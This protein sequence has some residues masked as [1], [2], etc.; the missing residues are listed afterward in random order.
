MPFNFYIIRFS[1]AGFDGSELFSRQIRNVNLNND[2]DLSHLLTTSINTNV[3]NAYHL[4]LIT[5]SNF[6]RITPTEE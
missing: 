4:F 5:K 1:V 6:I 2:V 3:C